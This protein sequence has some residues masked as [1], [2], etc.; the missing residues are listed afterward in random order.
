MSRSACFCRGATALL[1]VLTFLFSAQAVQA[2]LAVIGNW[3]QATDGGNTFTN[4]DSWLDWGSNSG[5]AGGP[6]GTTLPGLNGSPTIGS[7]P[8]Y[9]ASTIGAT[10]G[11]QSLGLSFSG[12]DQNLAIKLE[13]ATDL[14]GN[15]AKNDFF[16]DRAFAIDV[17]YAAQNQTSGFQ[18][19]Y[20]IGLNGPGTVVNNSFTSIGGNPVSSIG[21]KSTNVFYGAGPTS[22]FTYTLAVDYSSYLSLFTSNSYAELIF[23][24]NSDSLHNTFYFDNA[25]LYTPGDMNND[26]HVDSTDIAAMELALTNPT[27]YQTTYFNSNPNYTTSDMGLIGDV[28]GDGVFNNLDVQALLN[29]LLS[30]GGSVAPVPEPASLALLVL[31][32]PALWAV[33]KKRR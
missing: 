23:A 2:Q 16:N 31:A 18:Q 7:S 10:L 4:T 1:L 6:A 11:S 17:T 13:Y 25:R 3:E 27:L 19:I 24:T 20:D 8:V 21:G 15:N 28:N 14:S 26:G 22:D 30:G 9:S 29:K 32:I 33:K 12:Y 5:Y